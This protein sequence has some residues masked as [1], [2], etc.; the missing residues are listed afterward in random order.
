MPHPPAAQPGHDRLAHP[1]RRLL[2]GCALLLVASLP[3]QPPATT[4]PGR[5]E[6]YLDRRTVT[7]EAPTAACES[8]YD[9]FRARTWRV[10]LTTPAAFE[11]LLAALPLS[12]SHRRTLL[13]PAWRSAHPEGGFEIRPT[14]E[15]L[16]S[17]T[18]GE[19]AALY[20]LLARWE[21]NKPE[22]W[23]LVFADLTAL[24]RLQQPGYPPEFIRRVEACAYPFDGGL[25]FSDF[26]LLAAEFPDRAMLIG[27][28]QQ[29]SAS[30]GLVPR[31][32]LRHALSVGSALA[33]WTVDNNNS[34]AQPLLEALLHAETDEGV[35]LTALFPGAVRI[36]A[37]DIAPEQVRHDFSLRSFVIS[38]A[39]SGG[40]QVFAE[41]G[42][43]EP[44]FQ[45]NFVRV[46]APFRFGDLMV[47]ERPAGLPIRYACA[48][49][50]DDLAFAKDPV[51]LGLWG[52]LPL[53]DI[54]RRNP[55]FAGGTW[56][57][58][59][60]RDLTSGAAG[61][62]VRFQTGAPGPWGV[63]R[64]AALELEPPER[65]LDLANIFQ[66][67]PWEFTGEWSRVEALLRR[68]ELTPAQ[69]DALLNPAIR[70]TRPGGRIALTVPARLRLELSATSRTLLY[71]ELGSRGNNP[72][73]YI[74]LV[75][76]ADESALDRAG[77]NPTLREVMRR[78][79]YLRHG[80]H[81][82]SDTDLLEP[83]ITDQREARRLKGLLLGAPALQAELSRESLAYR[84]EV[85]AYWKK[86]DGRT[87]D[88]LLGWFKHSP[89]L[90]AID[91]INFLPDLPQQ[92]LNTYPET[93]VRERTNCYW[94]SFNFFARQPDN[95]F[96]SNALAGP[97]GQPII[98]EELRRS[99]H[100]VDPPYQ[101]GDVLCYMDTRPDGYGIIH[102]MNYIADD[103]V[104][105]KNGLSA[106]APTVF[107]RLSDV[108]WR[109]PTAFQLGMGGFRRNQPPAAP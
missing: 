93:V 4:Q 98:L 88:A 34:F 50:A 42:D 78:I 96:L 92:A 86:T 105:T 100:P 60:R 36:L 55:H 72:S 68:S 61:T 82:L 31:L 57:A 24:R 30:V 48:Y 56:V 13:T 26:S 23:P 41:I 49:L 90:A 97:N 71:D 45:R 18:F 75:L 63:L 53:A 16:R 40:P 37:H 21:A 107:M 20:A 7:F 35:E 89:D 29:A 102:M 66:P 103:V 108:A 44:W 62:N 43:F 25:A 54:L 12:D 64:T 79:S 58:Y 6:G 39:L 2:L 101:F 70:S 106:L 47:L 83:Y 74:P 59:R 80:R 84:R 87:T 69:L 1:L 67:Q 3:A 77:L 85:I 81:C 19:R 51:G 28:L 10:G 104:L 27:F 5:A 22:R 15:F 32:K 73:H 17:L 52:C 8:Y 38:A 33:Y 109:Y 11:A 14:D 94:T 9:T 65:W 46:A 95:R 91:L 99:Y 76:P